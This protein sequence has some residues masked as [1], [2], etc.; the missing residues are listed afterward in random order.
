MKYVLIAILLSGKAYPEQINLNL[1]DCAT[2]AA[3]T[4]IQT[5]GM[6]VKYKCEEMK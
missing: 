5:Y 3:L 2:Q 4:A 6:N 1:Q